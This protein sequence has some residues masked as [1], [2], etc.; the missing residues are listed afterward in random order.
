[1]KNPPGYGSVIDLGG[2]RRRPIAVRVPNGKKFNKQG[3]EIIDYKY[4]GYFERTAQGKKDAK[5]LLAQY[6]IGAAVDLPQKTNACPTFKEMADIWLEKHLEHIAL[7]KGQASRQLNDSY[8][9]AILKCSPIYGKRMDLVKYQDIQD[10]ADSI[11]SMSD[12]TVRNVKTV[13]FS[14]FDLARKQK[15]ITENFISDIDFIYKK[16]VDKIHSSF[17]RDEVS[18][19]WKHSEDR[20]VQIILV[21]IYTGLRIEELLAMKTENVHIEE[22]YM[23][24]GV[25]TDAGKDRII[26]IADKIFYFVRELYST[27]NKYLL[28]NRQ[29]RYSRTFFMSSI[30]NPTMDILSLSHLPHD[31]RYTCATMMD[32][33]GVSENTKKTILGHEKTG[34]TNKVYV[35]KDLQDLLD[36][37]NML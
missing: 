13:L 37:I 24:G 16:K 4:L 2:K 31:T 36:A 35:E 28:A 6:N 8:R 12:S 27:E 30:W 17:T 10:I 21:M 7:K 22:K 33:A 15:Y 3:K 18:L 20:N 23:I 9:A 1:M 19:L 26:P 11:S 14:V 25:K 29:K 5:T 34:I 32:R